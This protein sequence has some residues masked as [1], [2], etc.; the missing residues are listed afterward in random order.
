VT[1]L[2]DALAL[3][4]GVMLG[5]VDSSGWAVGIRGF[6]GRLARAQ[7]VL[8][9]GRSVYDPLFAGT[10]WEVQDTFIEDV[11]RIEVV[12]GPGGTLWGANAVNGIVSIVTRP[13]SPDPGGAAL[14]GRGD[15]RS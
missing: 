1:S 13:A 14:A 11:A 5:R 4:P 15:A 6:T 12:R 10:Y 8:L 2:A 9:D 3:V 7:L